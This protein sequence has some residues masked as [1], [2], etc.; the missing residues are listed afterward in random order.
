M[1]CTRAGRGLGLR[2]WSV[3]VGISHQTVAPVLTQPAVRDLVLIGGGHAHLTVLKRFG[4]R[5][6]PGVRL[7]LISR[8]SQSPYSGMLPGL[9]AGHYHADEM[10][11]DMRALADFAQARFIRAEVSGLDLPARRVLCRN[12]APIEFDL[13]SLNIGSTPSRADLT[14]ASPRITPVKPI[15]EFN[16]RWLTLKARVLAAPDRVRIGVVGGGA[17]GVELVL[18]MR[19]RLLHELA[20]RGR[21]GSHLEF[22]LVTATSEVLPSHNRRTRQTFARILATRRIRMHCDRRIVRVDADA[23]FAADGARIALDEV[24]WVT[25]A[26]PAPWL[27]AA[28]LAVDDTG[29]VRVSP[30]LRSVS[31]PHVFAVG[32]CATI[33]GAP[34]PK[35]GVYAVRQGG[36]L[37]GNLRRAC[38]GEPL[39]E[40][41]PQRDALSLISTGPRHAVASRGTWSL[42]GAWVW[43]WKDWIDWRFMR[44]FQT[45]PEGLMKSDRPPA[46][47]AAEVAELGPA[48]LRCGGCGAKVGAEV[49]AEALRVLSPAARPDIVIGLGGRDDAAITQVPAGQLAV[50]TIDGFRA[51][52][53]DPY[54]FGQIT[55]AHCLSDIFA[56]GAT[57]QSALAYVT[58]PLASTGLLR[59]DLSQLLAGAID[60]LEREG[61]ALV[62]GHTS[63]GAE[64][65]FAFAINGHVDAARMRA[66]DA[67]QAGDALILTKPLGTGVLLA[68]AMQRKAHPAWIDQALPQMIATNGPAARAIEGFDVH[69]MTDVTGFGLAGHLAEMLRRGNLQARLTLGDLPLLEGA[70][71]LAGRGIRSTLYR[72]NARL[73]P[74]I[75][76]VDEAFHGDRRP[77]LFDPQTSGGLLIAV[78][79]AEAG[80]CLSALHASGCRGAR[81]IGITAERER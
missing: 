69:A 22:H 28:G 54:V 49:I 47:I 43:R 45:L 6:L 67:L 62:G 3:T 5:P 2:V 17:G 63:E 32:D 37:A 56:M 16:A 34:R 50:H 52:V 73:D 80:E 30:A 27:A 18:A 19:H 70:E 65:A 57:P 4:M 76:L 64:L 59:R 58:L 31:H 36:P 55:A 41:R 53:S 29:Y 42:S 74:A 81:C 9:I 20:A 61:T 39:R 23:V 26:A 78:P 7:T 60:V 8:T 12:R 68:G 25:N 33:D 38:R 72:Q 11:I 75:D 13:L 1:Q 48:T 24:L 79:A 15:D 10:H 40:Y 14:I 71:E 77:L 35:S 51:F 46:A 66:K 21:D 44:K